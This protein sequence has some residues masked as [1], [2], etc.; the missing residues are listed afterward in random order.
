MPPA[1][2]NW[3]PR[4]SG[5]QRLARSGARAARPGGPDP[6]KHPGTPLPS[7]GAARW[8]SPSCRPF[9]SPGRFPLPGPGAPPERTYGSRARRVP[10]RCSITTV[11][12]VIRNERRSHPAPAACHNRT[13]SGRCDV[14]ARVDRDLVASARVLVGP[15]VPIPRASVRPH[16]GQHERKRIVHG[17]RVGSRYDC[18][19]VVCLGGLPRIRNRPQVRELLGERDLLVLEVPRLDGERRQHQVGARVRA[20]GKS[21]RV[22]SGLDPGR[23]PQQRCPALTV[24]GAGESEP[25]GPGHDMSAAIGEGR[26]GGDYRAARNRSPGEAGRRAAPPQE[27]RPGDGEAPPR[28][29][30]RRTARIRAVRF[31]PA[32]CTPPRAPSAIPVG[33]DPSS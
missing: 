26:N 22:V 30:R 16:Q 13:P 23:D 6:P 10:G 2:G 31:R 15:T 8:Q 28:A 25:G 7:A 17:V 4:G 12:P 27:W 9:R 3:G 11:H 19:Q 32:S 33:M 5:R 29:E 20:G 1:S 14:H 24:G 18:L 21:K